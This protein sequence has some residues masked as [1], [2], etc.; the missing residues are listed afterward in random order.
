[1]KNIKLFGKI[2][3]L[4]T[5]FYYC[6]NYCT[7]F[8]HLHFGIYYCSKIY[9]CSNYCSNTMYGSDSGR[10]VFKQ[11]GVSKGGY[12]IALM[13]CMTWGVCMTTTSQLASFPTHPTTHNPHCITPNQKGHDA[14]PLTVR[15]QFQGPCGHGSLTELSWIVFMWHM[16]LCK[17]GPMQTP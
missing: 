4:H 10:G 3:L 13:F 5:K 9:Y 16:T 2:L 15:L 8:G 1:M 14:D 7:T 17:L 6:S 12:E 11:K